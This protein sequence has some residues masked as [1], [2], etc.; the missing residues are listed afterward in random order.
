MYVSSMRIAVR[1][2]LPCAC[3]DF[4]YLH[5]TRRCITRE[6]IIYDLLAR[7]SIHSELSSSLSTFHSTQAEPRPYPLAFL[8]SYISLIATSLPTNIMT[9]TNNTPSTSRLAQK[10][11]PPSTFQ[12]ARTYSQ[13]QSRRSSLHGSPTTL[14][15]SWFLKSSLPRKRGTSLPYEVQKRTFFGMGEIV[16][17]IANVG[18]V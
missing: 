4:H 13:S 18:R 9:R 3:L 7:R 5:D 16:G 8:A 14:Q 10:P 2:P 11:H 17:V 1:N 6:F 15:V 12:R